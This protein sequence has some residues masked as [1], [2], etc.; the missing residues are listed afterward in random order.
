M[1]ELFQYLFTG[2]SIGTIYALIAVGFCLT[3]NTTGIINF[4]QGEFVMLGGMFAIALHGSL[5]CSLFPAILAS[6]LLTAG[7]GIVIERLAI[8]PAIGA[9]L[10]TLIIITIGISFIIKA[11]VGSITKDEFIL[12]ALPGP[13]SQSILGAT[14]SAQTI[15]SI[16]L[17]GAIVIA[18]WIFLKQT[19]V[20]ATLRALAENKQSI[21]NLGI[22]SDPLAMLAFSL[23]AAIGA[24][25]GVLITPITQ[26]SWLRGTELGLKGFCGAV[27]GG[28]GSIP[29]AVIG[30]LLIGVAETAGSAL[31][32]GYKDVIAFGIVL[33][34]LYT[35]PEGIM[36][37]KL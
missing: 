10:T 31:V 24:A 4:A 19:L 28:M 32:S 11:V 2:I 6:I 25:A 36:K 15:W 17:G 29:G 26:M 34:I 21:F 35:R 22:S 13:E 37:G 18:L 9:S 1:T 3:Y 5:G 8:R 14:I 23:S 27:L 12:P 30:G 16:V 33:L 20:G 7:V